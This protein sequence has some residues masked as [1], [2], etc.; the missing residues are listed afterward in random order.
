[1]RVKQ[2]GDRGRKN[3]KGNRRRQ[4]EHSGEVFEYIMCHGAVKSHSIDGVYLPQGF[5]EKFSVAASWKVEL[6]DNQ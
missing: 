2:I 1:M 5:T 6:T 4:K 3:S